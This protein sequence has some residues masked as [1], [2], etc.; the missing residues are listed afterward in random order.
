[1]EQEQRNTAQAR[2]VLEEE[3]CHQ[4]KQA[5]EWEAAAKA[6]AALVSGLKADVEDERRY[7]CW[8]VDGLMMRLE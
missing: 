8:E 2:E 1:M 7:A 4:R 6:Q 5:G 3:A